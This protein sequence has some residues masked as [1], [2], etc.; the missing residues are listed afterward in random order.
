MHRTIIALAVILVPLPVQAQ[1][2]PTERQLREDCSAFSQAGMADCLAKKAKES[3]A[4]VAAAE[5]RLRTR[6]AKWDEDAKFKTT[7]LARFAASNAAFIRYRAA[8]CAFQSSLGGGAIGN[9]L[10]MQ[11]LACVTELNLRRV[12]L[13]DRTGSDLP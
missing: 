5:A 12:E 3:G 4:G 13:L 10:S 2:L 7:A 8:A 1:S 6:L 9:A 11:R